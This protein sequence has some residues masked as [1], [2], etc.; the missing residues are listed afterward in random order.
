M[1]QT[2]HF[3][4]MNAQGSVGESVAAAAAAV[5]A[6]VACTSLGAVEGGVGWWWG[7]LYGQEGGCLGE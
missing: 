2:L 5:V 1:R 3:P 6:N 7:G 4:K